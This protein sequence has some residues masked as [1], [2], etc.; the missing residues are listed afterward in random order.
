MFPFVEWT[1]FL[2]LLNPDGIV[3]ESLNAVKV[4]LDENM[5]DKM[6]FID[7][8]DMVSNPEQVMEDIYD[9]LGE[10]HYEHTFDGLSNIHRENDLNTYG[11]GDMHEV[12]SK[13]EKTSSS[14]E[15]VLPKEILDLYE[16]NKQSLEFWTSK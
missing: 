13:L 16:Q 7:Y 9:F 10:E 6:H 14:P 15:S 1:R 11:L 3:Y 5:R 2:H 4:G 8:N 12:H